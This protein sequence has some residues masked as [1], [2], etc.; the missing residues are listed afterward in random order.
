MSSYKELEEFFR[1]KG[2]TYQA[3]HAGMRAVPRI[4]VIDIPE[5]WKEIADQVSIEKK[6]QIF[7]SA[8]LPIILHAN[9][10]ILE[11]RTRAEPLAMDMLEG[12]ELSSQDQKW[13]QALALRY[14]VIDE[15]ETLGKDQLKRLIR[16][17]DFI[18]PSLALAQAAYESAYATSRFAGLG[19]ALFGQWTYSRKGIRPEQQRTHLG[20]YKV[21][22]FETPLASTLSYAFNLNTNK[23]YREFR[24]KRAGFI[25]SGKFP[26]PIVL[27]GTLIRYSERGEEYT[28]EI[29]RVI[30]QNGLYEADLAYLREME[31][32]FLVPKK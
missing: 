4:Y 27:A 21:A 20:D 16:R 29:Q 17:I 28:K 13:M 8:I 6:K 11:E 5:K 31:P 12:E 24:K 19:N 26:D 10:M 30:Q 22:A 23:A 1:Q 18:P 25:H 7:F 2:F 14:K 9:E 32:I 15:G 3:W